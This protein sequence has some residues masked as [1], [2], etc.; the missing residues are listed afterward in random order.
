M[1]KKN[2]PSL[3]LRLC[4]TEGVLLAFFFS[5]VPE[6]VGVFLSMTFSM[7]DIK[8]EIKEVRGEVGGVFNT[9]WNEIVEP[10]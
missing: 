1:E 6:A 10:F 5:N 8:S 4:V 2:C 3:S 7:S 9:Y